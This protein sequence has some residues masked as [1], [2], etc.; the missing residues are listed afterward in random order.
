MPTITTHPTPM[1]IDSLTYFADYYEVTPEE[2]LEANSLFDD[3]I[4]ES[5]EEV[6][7]LIR[8]H[9]EISTLAAIDELLHV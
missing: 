8:D 5:V 6:I 9:K 3:T 1:T 4:D 7:E 2:L